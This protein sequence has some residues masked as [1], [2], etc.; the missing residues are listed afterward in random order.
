MKARL[1]LTLMALLLLIMGACTDSSLKKTGE[2]LL[3]TV[4]SDVDYVGVVDVEEFIKTTA[5]KIKDHRSVVPSDGLETILA[6]IADT[7][8]HARLDSLLAGKTGVDLT[9]AV[10]FESDGHM[11]ITH[12]LGDPQTLHDYMK[13][14]GRE[15]EKMADGLYVGRQIAATDD[16]VWILVGDTAA[17]VNA[18]D[19]ERFR[20]LNEN[21][22]MMASPF[23][24][25]LTAFKYDYTDLWK[26][27]RLW[28]QLGDQADRARMFAAFMMDDVKYM[29]F[30]ADL[31]P[32]SFVA[33]GSFLNSKYK[34]AKC[35]LAT[36]RLS[37]HDFD[38]LCPTSQATAGIALDQKLVKNLL[39]GLKTFGMSVPKATE[40]ALKNLDG[41]IVMATDADNNTIVRISCK[42]DKEESVATAVSA[43]ATLCG[44]DDANLRV[45]TGEGNVLVSYNGGPQTGVTTDILGDMLDDAWIGMAAS[46]DYYE[47]I[48][49]CKRLALFL[50]PKGSTLQVVFRAMF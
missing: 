24:A 41:P 32:G 38:D 23:A 22:S 46:R 44:I 34:E 7:T 17:T 8:V 9:C 2:K 33:R 31:T 39:N 35:N 49:P 50:T 16:Q 27:N 28:R 29:S 30:T 1:S 45:T 36:G 21:Q 18:A 26:L 14:T 4:P 5:S 3:S 19:I 6:R 15:M 40:A 43:T 47:A 20:R 48:A 12:P 13:R 37:S 42:K 11:W 25:Q 10:L